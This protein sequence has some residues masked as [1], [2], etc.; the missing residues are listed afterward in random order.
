MHSEEHLVLETP[1]AAEFKIGDVLYG[2]PWHI[3][4][5]VALAFVCE[6]RARRPCRRA[7]ACRGPRANHQRLMN[8]PPC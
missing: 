4:P 8:A 3:C 1:R 7:M 6:R 2:V 5:T